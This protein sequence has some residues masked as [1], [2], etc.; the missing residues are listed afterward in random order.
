MR[1]ELIKALWENQGAFGLDLSDHT[2]ERL[3]KF[4]EIVQENNPLLHLVAPC[5][6]EEFA[7]RH[8][9]ESMV[10]LSYLP[11]DSRFADVGTGAG[12][13][14]IPCLIARGDLS[15]TLIDSKEKKSRYLKDAVVQLGL[16]NR[17]TVVNKQFEEVREK[18]FDAVTCRALDRFPE[19]LP[20]LLKWTGNRQ[21]L[22]FGGPAIQQALQ[23]LNTPYEQKLMPL[24]SQRYLFV[25]K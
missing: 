19:K 21:F 18:E 11:R 5:S 1:D 4:Y 14:S 16:G 3:A 12:L 9:L 10:L 22:C 7:I 2:A 25:G 6:A 24:S 15:A 17:A 20:R 13:P 23:S 8:I